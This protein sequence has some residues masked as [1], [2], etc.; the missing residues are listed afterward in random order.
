AMASKGCT[1][2]SCGYNTDHGFKSRQA[3]TFRFT[4][5]EEQLVIPGNSEKRQDGHSLLLYGPNAS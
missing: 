4:D 3:T 1:V 2:E 5:K